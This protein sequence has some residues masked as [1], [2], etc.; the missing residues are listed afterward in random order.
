MDALNRNEDR[1]PNPSLT[2]RLICRRYA[3]GVFHSAVVRDALGACASNHWALGAFPNGKFELLG[4]WIQPSADSKIPVEVFADF[5]SRGLDRIRYRVGGHLTW[6]RSGQ[7]A[8]ALDN[9]EFSPWGQK[10][11]PIVPLW[12]LAL[13]RWRP[14]LNYSPRFDGWCCRATSRRL[15]FMPA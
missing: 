2:R 6:A 5:E 11:P 1:S 12:S 4:L 13:V 7:A 3:L 8:V 14:L 10:C 15:S 9:F